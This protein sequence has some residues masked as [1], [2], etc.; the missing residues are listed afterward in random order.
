MN[1]FQLIPVND[2]ADVPEGNVLLAPRQRLR[3]PVLPLGNNAQLQT[4]VYSRAA[5]ASL[6]NGVEGG[7]IAADFAGSHIPAADGGGD[8]D[9]SYL[10]SANFKQRTVSGVT[11]AL[12][13][14]VADYPTKISFQSTSLTER[15]DV[16][17]NVMDL[18]SFLGTEGYE[19]VDLI[20][21]QL[22]QNVNAR[23]SSSNNQIRNFLFTL[24]RQGVSD[25]KYYIQLSLRFRWDGSE[26]FFGDNIFLAATSHV[27]VTS[28]NDMTSLWED[29]MDALSDLYDFGGFGV[30]DGRERENRHSGF[31]IERELGNGSR[32][33]N[34]NDQRMVP[35]DFGGRLNENRDP[36]DRLQEPNVYIPAERSFSMGLTVSIV[37]QQDDDIARRITRQRPRPVSVFDRAQLP[38]AVGLPGGVPAGARAGARAGVPVPVRR[39][40]RIMRLNRVEGGG[41]CYTQPKDSDERQMD[42]LMRRKQSIIMIKNRD[43][44]CFAR[45][46][47]TL[48]AKCLKYKQVLSG[49]QGSTRISSET[50]LILSTVFKDTLISQCAAIQRGLKPQGVAAK[51]LLDFVG[52]SANHTVRFEDIP[53]FSD[54]L[55]LKIRVLSAVLGFQ[56]VYESGEHESTVYVI[57]NK[58]HYHALLS[59][60]GLRNQGYECVPCMK[61]FSSRFAHARCKDRCYYCMEST[62][63]RIRAGVWRQCE[64]CN[65]KFPSD[66]CFARHCTARK[67][68]KSVCEIYMTCGKFGCKVFKR[69]SYADLAQHQCGD[70]LC[71]NC[72]KTVQPVHDC[73]MQITIPKKPLDKVV[74]FD[75]ECAQDTGEHVITHAV[76]SSG[77]DKNFVEF[78]PQGN[79]ISIVEDNF[80]SWVFGYDRFKGYTFIAHNGQGYDFHFIQR[81][82]VNRNIV[83][84]KVI[85]S[86]QKLRHMVV[87]GVRF[88]DSLSFLTMPLSAFPKTF[89]IEELAKGYFPHLFN[90]EE[91][92]GYVGCYPEPFYYM[93]DSMSS[94][95]RDKFYAWYNEASQGVF[96]FNV[97]IMKYCRSDVDILKRAVLKF[98]SLFV[99]TTG[100]DPLNHV[101]IAGAC[102]DVYRSKFL[103]EE[104]ISLLEPDVAKWIRSGFY[105]GRTQVFQGH[106]IADTAQ[107]EVIK[108][109]D[110]TSLYPWVNKH[111]S[112]PLGTGALTEYPDP[113]CDPSLVST[114]VAET[115]GF[116][117]VDIQCPTDLLI[118]VLGDRTA[119]GLTFD[120]VP[121]W[122]H[123][124]CSV[125]LQKAVSMGYVVT[126][127]HKVLHWKDSGNILFE[128]YV[129]CFL[130]LKQEASGWN[131]KLV[132][133]QQV[134]TDADKVKWVSAYEAADGVRLDIDNVKYN[135]G[136]RA[137]SKL[138]LNSL[139]GKMGQNPVRKKVVFLTDIEELYTHLG[140]KEHVVTNV[141]EVGDNDVHELVYSDLRTE[142]AVSVNSCVALAAFTTAHAR[143]KLYSALE[144]L[145]DRA[146]YCDTDSVIYSVKPGETGIPEGDCLGEWTDE[147]PGDHIVEFVG[148]G[149]KSYAYRTASGHE[150]VKSKGFSLSCDN[151]KGALNFDNYRAAVNS[152]RHGSQAVFKSQTSTAF[153]IVRDSVKKTV[154]T[155]KDVHKVFRPT[156]DR[157]GVLDT[158]SHT[159]RIYPFG[160]SNDIDL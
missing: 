21:L 123:V 50:E 87:C 154:N 129:Q 84:K 5:R 1:Y 103:R 42:I 143:L 49:R 112:Y 149:P 131:G 15:W 71:V 47:V 14:N 33:F 77:C 53:L 81:W 148:C 142:G 69:S 19:T 114:I 46:L 124:V 8:G 51:L 113:V 70:I 116:L 99:E 35:Q 101:S 95:G 102:L 93:A 10:P 115:F 91:N 30:N 110:V 78:C 150:C 13:R 22:L 130:K 64:S 41:G 94:A 29:L 39:S 86:G 133:G 27:P 89:G 158:K 97:E 127:V 159:L 28:Y 136:M 156:L 126:K 140:D 108:Y 146:I 17:I 62:C 44:M 2:D 68:G 52:V 6:N 23:S 151:E 63:E 16:G 60:K 48:F 134:V 121:K 145:G 83:P 137:I 100:V 18:N 88:I 11:G 155:K 96:D 117:E 12:S 24:S 56:K 105:G 67:G 106:V 160:Y 118:P 34:V 76:A 153:R 36:A 3:G 144:V 32:R 59:L 120:L 119:G 90:T 132:A 55:Q 80:C 75:F 104:S 141:T 4:L 157:K 147:T 85:R 79:D 61:V 57:L 107:C 138:C 37:R 72:K 111:C 135:P 26:R 20:L 128:E 40:A 38:N 109:M 45:A 9:G 122:N 92:Q 74:F 152:L 73:F 31:F 7:Q 82:V 125:E 43:H 25:F 58:N 65:R 98:Q 54:K 66:D 139:W